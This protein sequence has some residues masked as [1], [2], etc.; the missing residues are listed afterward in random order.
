MPNLSLLSILA[1]MAMLYVGSMWV[2]RMINDRNDEILT[3]V[4]K[5]VPVSVKD[6]QLMLFTNWL[7]YVA[8][9]IAFQLAMSVGLFEVGRGMEEPRIG[10]VAYIGAVMCAATAIFWVFLAPFVFLSMLS[11]L[12]KA[13]VS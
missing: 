2:V 7:P 8:F 6:R 4:I 5:G 13:A 10:A 9:L 11:A 12:R 1:I 3:G